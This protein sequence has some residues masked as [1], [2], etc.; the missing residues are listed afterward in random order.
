MVL[1]VVDRDNVATIRVS[2]VEL[3]AQ[4]V[5]HIRTHRDAHAHMHL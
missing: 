4:C 1:K 5:T 2:V 3:I